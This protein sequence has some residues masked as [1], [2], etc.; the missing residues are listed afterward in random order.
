MSN[1]QDEP[2]T[3]DRVKFWAGLG[4]GIALGA[5]AMNWY[6]VETI[7]QAGEICL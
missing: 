6:W 5:V 1:Q 2:S 7:C 4:L 3:W